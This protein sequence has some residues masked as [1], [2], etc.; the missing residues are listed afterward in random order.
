MAFHSREI[1]L[2][3]RELYPR[4]WVFRFKAWERREENKG[5]SEKAQG[6][7]ERGPCLCLLEPIWSSVCLKEM[8]LGER[9]LAPLCRVRDCL[10][11]LEPPKL[12]TQKLA[13]VSTWNQKH[14]TQ[15]H[16]V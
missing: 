11:W 3:V 6:F 5:I 2:C 9:R 15:L 7:W 12:F 8:P 4:K 13:P 10:D 1:L 16:G 14:S